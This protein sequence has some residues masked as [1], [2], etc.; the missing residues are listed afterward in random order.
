MIT[1]VNLLLF[2]KHIPKAQKQEL[3]ELFP[4]EDSNAL[5]N[6]LRFNE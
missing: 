6:Y 4:C 1:Q 2:L 5:I 3:V